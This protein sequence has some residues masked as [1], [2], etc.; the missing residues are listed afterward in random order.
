MAKTKRKKGHVKTGQLGF[1]RKRLSLH[2]LQTLIGEF[3]C[4]LAGNSACPLVLRKLVLCVPFCTR[5]GG[6]GI[7]S[8]PGPSA[9]TCRRFLEAAKRTK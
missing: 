7:I 8:W 6:A 1:S 2:T 5:S 4:P 3:F 9:D